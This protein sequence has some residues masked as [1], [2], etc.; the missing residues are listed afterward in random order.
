MHQRDDRSPL[1]GV[2]LQRMFAVAADRPSLALMNRASI[3]ELWTRALANVFQQGSDEPV[4]GLAL[5]PARLAAG[6]YR[7][8]G[9]EELLA[10]S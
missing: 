2:G 7:G 3:Q 10:Q 4:R 6:Q 5:D 8:V 1:P 9:V